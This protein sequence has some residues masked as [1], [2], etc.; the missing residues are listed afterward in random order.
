[1]VTTR[2]LYDSV[3]SPKRPIF[4]FDVY[5]TAATTTTTTTTTTTYVYARVH[6]VPDAACVAAPPEV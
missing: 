4:G 3:F 6:G 1:M 2:G 5:S